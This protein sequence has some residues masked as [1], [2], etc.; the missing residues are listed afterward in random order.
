MVVQKSR[1]PANDHMCDGGEHSENISDT[2]IHAT[3]IMQ[4]KKEKKKNTLRVQC[5]SDAYSADFQP[6]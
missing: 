6:E 1:F 3:G 5:L 2:N 4:Q